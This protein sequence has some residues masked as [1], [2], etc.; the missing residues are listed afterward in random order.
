MAGQQPPLAQDPL[1]VGLHARGIGLEPVEV[2]GQAEMLDQGEHDGARAHGVDA[3]HVPARARAALGVGQA[4]VA[5]GEV[6]QRPVG[7]RPGMVSAL[8][9]ARS[10][11]PSAGQPLVQSVGGFPVHALEVQRAQDHVGLRGEDAEGIVVE[12]PLPVGVLARIG[13]GCA[14]RP[15]S[16]GP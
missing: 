14:R 11:A 7:Q 3:V 9:R 15:A 2:A 6:A 4:A 16:T 5:V 10:W 13:G 1:G 8:P 12:A